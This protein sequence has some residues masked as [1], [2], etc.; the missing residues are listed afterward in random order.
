MPRF[1]RTYLMLLVLLSCVG[2]DQIS[3]TIAKSSL[4][5]SP[6]ISYLGETIRLQYAENS[7]AFLSLGSGFSKRTR[8]VLFTVLSGVLLVALVGY[9]LYNQ[10]IGRGHTFALSLILGGGVS[11]LLDRVFND[12]KVIDFLNMGIGNLR[13]GIFN[14]A[15]VVIMTGMALVVLLNLRLRRRRAAADDFSDAGSETE[16]EDEA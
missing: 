14:L 3:K 4:E 9:I 5:K 2:C 11:N 1:Q 8:T 16:F 6:P 12:G 7:G 10:D 13:T 15:D